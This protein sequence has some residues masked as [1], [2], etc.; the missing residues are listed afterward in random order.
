M[1][2]DLVPIHDAITARVKETL[3]NAPVKEDTFPDDET[4]ARDV[5][6]Q[7]IPYIILRYGPLR[8]AYGTGESVAGVRHDNYFGTVDVMAIAPQGRMARRLFDVLVDCLIGFDPGGGGSISLEGSSSNFAVS[9]NEARPT[10][11]V[12]MVRMKFPVNGVSVGEPISAGF[13]VAPFGQG[14]FGA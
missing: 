3:P 8:K 1:G 12:C 2:F 7:L 4:P 13:G 6:M 11:M 14:D 5:H 10:Q 9:S